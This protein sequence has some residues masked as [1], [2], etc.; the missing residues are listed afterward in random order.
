MSQGEKAD[1]VVMTY[2]VERRTEEP[3]EYRLPDDFN[4]FPMRQ[5]PY[6]RLK[7]MYAETYRHWDGLGIHRVYW[8]HWRKWVD[9]CVQ[10]NV[11][12][13]IFAISLCEQHFRAQSSDDDDDDGDDGDDENSGTVCPKR[14]K[15]R[16][17]AA[18]TSTGLP[19]RRGRDIDQPCRRLDDR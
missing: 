1:Q 3:S 17:S 9:A 19:F 13:K 4:H 11:S 6:E 15:Q 12:D 5:I 14:K 8:D 10:L 18:M 16:R 2:T 7:A